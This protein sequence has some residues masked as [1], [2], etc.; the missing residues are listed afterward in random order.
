M[1]NSAVYRT[2]WETCLAKCPPLCM[3]QSM[4]LC[5]AMPCKASPPQ[6]PSSNAC[7]MCL[8]FTLQLAPSLLKHI[9]TFIWLQGHIL[10]EIFMHISLVCVPTPLNVA[11][12]VWSHTKSIVPCSKLL[13]SVKNSLR[14]DASLMEKVTLMDA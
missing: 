10:I 11:P 14:S 3:S 5:A 9:S 8:M 4:P 6:L 7:V 13:L 1:I 2:H 12:Q